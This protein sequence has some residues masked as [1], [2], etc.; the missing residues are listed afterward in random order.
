MWI[1]YRLVNRT[2]VSRI[3]FKEIFTWCKSGN[4]K[5]R[6]NTPIFSGNNYWQCMALKNFVV[7]RGLFYFALHRPINIQICR[8]M[9]YC[10]SPCYAWTTAAFLLWQSAYCACKPWVL[11]WFHSCSLVFNHEYC[12]LLQ[13]QI[14]PALHEREYL[15]T[16][17]FSQ[18]GATP[19]IGRQVKELIRAQFGDGR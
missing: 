11:Y 3:H 10:N 6:I 2:K 14:I 4:L 16:S 5:T 9:G 19:H 12:E 7:K 18:Y 13:Q 8:C 17:V 15:E 1:V